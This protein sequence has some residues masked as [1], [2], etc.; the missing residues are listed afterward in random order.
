MFLMKMLQVMGAVFVRLLIS[1][2]E[3]WVQVERLEQDSL[4]KA[5]EWKIMVMVGIV[6]E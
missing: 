1:T 3:R 6:A 4:S 2:K 5:L